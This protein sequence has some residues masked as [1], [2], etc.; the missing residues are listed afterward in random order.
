MKRTKLSDRKLPDYT[1][2]EEIMNMTTHIVGGALAILALIVCPWLSAVH[3][4]AIGIVSSAIYGFSNFVFCQPH[5]H[6]Y[7]LR[8][9]YVY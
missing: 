5:L 7:Y 8:S 4:N 3:K 1:K 6:H 2:G 9:N